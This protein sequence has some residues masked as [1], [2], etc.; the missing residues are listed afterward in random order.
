MTKNASNATTNDELAKSEAR[1]LLGINEDVILVPAKE[2]RLV[3]DTD[4]IEWTLTTFAKAKA[5]GRYDMMLP[6]EI[7][8]HK[9]LIAADLKQIKK[10]HPVYKWNFE[11]VENKWRLLKSAYCIEKRAQRM[12]TGGGEC[13]TIEHDQLYM[14]IIPDT[15]PAVTPISHV[16]S[17]RGTNTETENVVAQA[18]EKAL[19]K[20]ARKRKAE[21][22]DAITKKIT[23]VLDKELSSNDSRDVIQLDLV[24]A[25]N[26]A[27][28]LKAMEL[29]KGMSA[30]K[31]KAMKDNADLLL[32]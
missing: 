30:D 4:M 31:I 22:A 12:H 32:Q 21:E 7:K 26:N 20:P 14:N 15:H 5:D 10:E 16:E 1:K 23:L 9:M 29:A 17:G 24:K 28:R 8:K 25:Q 3:W 6:S 18:L 11:S 27:N 13:P 19:P 2:K